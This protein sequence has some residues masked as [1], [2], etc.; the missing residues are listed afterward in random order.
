M[1][2]VR[3]HAKLNLGLAVT[4]RRDDG[5]HDIDSVIVPLDWHDLVGVELHPAGAGSLI[6]RLRVT[7]PGAALVPPGPGNLAQ[8]AAEAVLRLVDAS[9]DVWLDKHLPV[10]AGLGGGSADAAAVLRAVATLAIE[11][12]LPV[13]ALALDR[14]AAELG[15]DV[16]AVMA[17]RPVRVRGRGDQ[18]LRFGAVPLFV[19]VAVAGSSATP[20]TYAE[21]RPDEMGETARIADLAAAVTKGRPADALCGSA[22]EAAA[23][24]VNPE[25]AASLQCLRAATAPVIWHLTGSGGAAFSITSD[26][27]GAAVLAQRAMELGL[28]ARACHSDVR[29]LAV[30]T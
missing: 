20:A 8:R 9:V 22:L 17:S 1:L 3:A 23:C 25:L 15:S 24:R 6:A 30:R 11:R 10:A 19:A 29:S 18:L 12:G 28:Q 21:L 13:D 14:I 7:G 2:I 26:P 16:P 4:A 5:W 27:A